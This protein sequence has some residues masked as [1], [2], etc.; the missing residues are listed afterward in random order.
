M[1]IVLCGGHLTPAL[2]LLEGFQAKKDLEIFF[3][4]R[5]HSTEGNKN[6]SAEYRQL[7]SKK[8]K[9][10]EITAGRFQRKFTK[11]TIPSLAKIP[12]GFIQSFV[13][14]LII[15]PKVVVAFGGYLSLPV[16]FCA[17]LL[18]IDSIIHEQSSYPGLANRINAIFAKKI[19]LT[20]PQTQQ[21]FPKNKSEV[22]GNL[23]SSSITS[24][25]AKDKNLDKFLQKSTNIIFVTGGNQGSHFLNVLTRDLALRLKVFSI[26]HQVGT[27]NYKSDMEKS[28][29]IKSANYMAVDYL[30]S[31]NIGAA[32]NNA[33]LVIA[34]SGANT[35]WDLAQLAKVAILIP[36]PISASD[37]QAKNAQILETA[38][39]ALVIPQKEATV[40]KIE[41]AIDKISKNLNS[42]KVKSEN[43]KKTLPRGASAKV[44]EYIL[45]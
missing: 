24:T 1:R 15:R 20:W 45:S 27:A 36:L 40:D 13:Q 12:I 10:V 31:E 3:F 21:Y 38:G 32:Y 29:R 41:E 28:K 5:K 37:E 23:T 17:W 16:V 42:H 26:L 39:S 14:L 44:A 2:A 4:G 43:F 6:L 19:F 9:F 18:G 30:D 33:Q 8:L 34:R 7:G 22:T 35:V 25:H 11:Y